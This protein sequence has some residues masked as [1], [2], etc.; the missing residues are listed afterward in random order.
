METAT[1]EPAS[2]NPALAATQA[3]H[4]LAAALHAGRFPGLSPSSTAA[5]VPAPT[6]IG[7]YGLLRELGRGGMGVVYLGYDE[8]LERKVAVKLLAQRTPS[9][10]AKQRLEREAQA[11][12]RL[13]H[14]N[15]VQIYERGDHHGATFVVME[16][17]VGRTLRVWLAEPGHD[18]RAR[19]SLLREC[20]AALAAAH[21]QGLVH[22]DFKPD[23]VI[24]G[25]DGHARVLDF[26]IALRVADEQS[27]PESGKPD[28]PRTLVA[29]TQTGSLMGTPAYM[30]PE[31]WQARPCDARSDQF[32]FCVV[33]IEALFGT[34]PFR[35]DTVNTLAKA[36]CDGAVIDLPHG[37][38]VSKSLRLALL[39]GL[40][41]QPD[42]RWPDLQPLLDALD[43]ELDSRRP[44]RLVWT[45][46]GAG[47][48]A[49]ALPFVRGETEPPA[50]CEIDEHALRA[51]W[52]ADDR[53]ALQARFEPDVAAKIEARLDTW[54]ASWLAARAHVCEATHVEGTQST[55][56]LDLRM[57]CLELERRELEQ[58]VTLLADA[59][60]PNDAR[61][62]D[63]LDALPDP[64]RCE[65][66][67]LGET[68]HPL[69]DDP[70]ERAAI[71][72]AYGE[73]AR[74]RALASLR[75]FDEADAAIAGLVERVEPLEYV[76]LHIELASLAGQQLAWRRRIAEAVPRLREAIG[77]AERDHL[78][79]LSADLRVE[80]A[81]AVAGRW[82]RPEV[83]AVLLD[84]AELALARQALPNPRRAL[85]LELARARWQ[86]R[87]GD[88][89]NAETRLLACIA[90]ADEA[91][92]PELARAARRELGHMFV[93]LGRFDAAE[94][95][96]A[97][98]YQLSEASP[99]LAAEHRL[100]LGT[101]HM[102]RGQLDVAAHDYAAV[103]R[104][105]GRSTTPDIEL[106]ALLELARAKLAFLH[107]DL[108][109]ADLA[110][111]R[112]IEL[113]IDDL[114]VSEAREARGV[115]GFFR[116]DYRASLDHY[117]SALVSRIATVGSEDP[118][119][120]LLHSNIG[121]SQAALGDHEAALDS[122]AEALDLLGRSLPPD[123]PDLAF[124]YK[125][126]GKSRHALGREDGAILDL[127]Q[128]LGLHQANPGEPVEHADVEFALADVL[129]ATGE[130]ARAR[131]S[132]EQ[133]RE[134][135]LALGH[136]DQ[137]RVISQWL[138]NHEE[139][140][141]P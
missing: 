43:R 125:G 114:R 115:I 13:S 101:L 137:A 22:R 53:A 129:A 81:L 72:Q 87:T 7:R 91:S 39:R 19:A 109:A 3:E 38:G 56:L 110:F 103:E 32:S 124:P 54:S 133:A 75:R 94:Q 57:S 130:P 50:S 88:Y 105:L 65:D 17:V 131:T 84:E 60:S 30:S 77:M 80:L 14:P 16:Y 15:V 123:H 25:S 20:G 93:E 116:G 122:Y 12:A 4:R 23:N 21:A 59:G 6:R 42:Q 67:R 52:D 119:V 96:Y 40:S 9:D 66:P 55:E 118:S 8:Q 10:L 11:L 70:L 36:V 51:A 1:D 99:A 63:Q 85:R 82:G 62:L 37:L 121:E 97:A 107:G 48:V 34:R 120:G 100:M 135:L 64:A 18:F 98:A 27:E 76:P 24:V 132:A 47:V 45:L 112:V 74:V 73:L 140:Q 46:A 136:A 28:E 78:D 58:L 134:R 79:E 29:L 106:L 49:L 69:P 126:R 139:E 127:E 41:A 33:A 138:A 104:E 31:Q 26:G 108:D 92:L 95:A 90:A 44:R 102:R 2:E 128:A 5:S 117:R 61:A 89:A 111:A 113:G 35:G 68:M 141:K 71:E 86:V 83:Q